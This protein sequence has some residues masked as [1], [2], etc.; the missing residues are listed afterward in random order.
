MNGAF[1]SIVLQLATLVSPPWGDEEGSLDQGFRCA[2][3]LARLCR[4][5]GANV[6]L[7]LAVKLP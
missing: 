6:Q 2:P 7:P 4:P 1:E 5:V 3:P